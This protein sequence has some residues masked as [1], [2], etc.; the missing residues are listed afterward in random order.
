MGKFMLGSLLLGGFPGVLD[1][2]PLPNS[3]SVAYAN[4]ADIANPADRKRNSIEG[5]PRDNLEGTR[6]MQVVKCESNLTL[7]LKNWTMEQLS[8]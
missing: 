1:S 8:K 3:R 2:L 6:R 5:T 7:K 4:L